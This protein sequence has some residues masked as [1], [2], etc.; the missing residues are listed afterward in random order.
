[1]FVG[2][3]N[4]DDLMP[5]A[6]EGT[7]PSLSFG[8]APTFS[9]AAPDAPAVNFVFEDPELSVDLPAAP[10][11]MSLNIGAFSGLNLP[12]AISSE[13]PELNI[14]AP[15]A[16]PYTPG[17]AYTSALL[18]EV[19]DTLL[20]RIQNGGTGLN[21]AAENAIWERGR[22][23]EYKQAADALLE[24]D[25]MEALGYSL[26]PG[27]YVD[28]RI[29]IQTEL[30]AQ[31]AGHSREVMIKQAE[32]ELQNV[33]QSLTLA[34]QLEATLIQN[35]NA[36]EQRMFESAR[37]ATQAGIEIYNARVRAYAAYV[38][39]Y[40]TRVQIYEA[41]IRGEIAKVEAYK[42]QVE[43]E[44]SKAQINTAL[45]QQYKAQIEAAALANE[46]FVKQAAGAAPKKV[47]VVPGRLVN[48]V[49]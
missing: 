23:R 46:A 10:S 2:S 37:Y 36:A 26:P 49:V 42:A 15:S 22:E 35:A 11:L 3:L 40:K 29:K 4:V 5:A 8:V 28:G 39:A 16:I 18:T 13:I 47:I 27:A 1:M 38:D 12:T 33:Q 45:V 44:S 48:V 30:A 19:Q 34:N 43:A 31:A 25:R 32:L 17:A 24:L 7:A 14:G 21:A 6:F 9:E 41:Q 20:D